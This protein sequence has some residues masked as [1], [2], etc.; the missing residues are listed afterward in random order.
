[1]GRRALRKVNPAVDVAKFLF[2]WGDFSCPF[3]PHE[4]FGRT[5]PLEVEVGS[6][7]GMFLASVAARHPERDFLGI[8]CSHKYAHFAAARLAKSQHTNAAIVCADAARV[9]AEL[10]SDSSAEAV[11]I[12]FPD[13]WW[14]RRHHKRRV[15]SEEFMAHV[16]RVLAPGGLLHFWTDVHEY[17]LTTLAMIAKFRSLEGPQNVPERPAEHD[18]DYRTHFERRTRQLGQPVY[19]AE[20]RKITTRS[21]RA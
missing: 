11:H 10:L 14:K 3:Q 15:I 9:F 20:F 7:K 1:M 17:F 18:L 5:A 8:E 6:G 19:R 13:P 2:A 16:D 21:G 12:Y 4:V